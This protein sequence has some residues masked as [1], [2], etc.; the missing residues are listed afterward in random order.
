MHLSRR[1][2][3]FGSF[4]L[5]AIAAKKAAPERPNVL[6]LIA[7]NVP[8]W[9][10]GAYGNKEIRTPNLDRL[11]R[12]GTRFLDSYAAAPSPVPSR[13]TLLTG[14]APGRTGAS[15]EN[16]LA[17]AGYACN[18]ATD[19]LGA[20]R[21]IDAATPGKP[22][23]AAVN[24]SS[25]RAPYD[26][27]AQKYLDLYAQTKFDT[28]EPEPAAP[29][30]RAG[31]ELLANT[32]G[33]L[34]KYAAAVTAM[35]DEVQ[36]LLAKVAQR[37]M[38]DQTLVIFTSTCG[39]L[40]SHHGLWDAGEA[41]EPVNMYEESV[42]TPLI[43]S[44]TLRVPPQAV[45]PEIVSAYDLVPT[46]CEMV[47]VDAPAGNL[48]GRSYALLAT[49]KPLPKKQKWQPTVFAHLQNTWMARGERYKLVLRDGGKGE[50]YDTQTDPAEKTN[51]I[52]NQQFLSVKTQLTGEL[53]AWKQK[54]S[55]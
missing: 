23:F 34:R 25:P 17:P 45:R 33:N 29:N 3:F 37:R 36:S 48:C 8:R 4:A 21:I 32:I 53:A 30:A 10:V 9:V 35:D 39:A 42:G 6:L 15:V 46:L 16:V 44:W 31:K 49:G 19:T 54:Y 1:H 52:D 38:G 55:A 13:A 40:L 26:G 7:D 12:M 20:A 24:L 28:F 47:G 50:L 14:L 5:P 41:S 43:W 22:F 18:S 2:F 11:A 27:V 51:Q